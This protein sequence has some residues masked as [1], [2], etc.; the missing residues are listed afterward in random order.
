[1]ATAPQPWDRRPDEP[2]KAWYAFTIYRDLGIDKRSLRVVADRISR[3]QELEDSG[4]QMELPPVLTTVDLDNPDASSK[5]VARERQKKVHGRLF[6]WSSKYHW[7]DRCKGW[8]A[9]CQQHIE[10]RSLDRAEETFRRQQ[11]YN[12]SLAVSCSVIPAV[13]L[14]KLNTP[15]G[16]AW[17]DSIPMDD[18]LGLVIELTSRAKRM[19]D[20][21]RIALGVKVTPNEDAVRHFF[22]G[23]ETVQP[24]AKPTE[25]LEDVGSTGE[26]PY[27]VPPPHDPV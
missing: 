19:Q 3:E 15:E 5:R 2:P 1:M 22:W 14:R 20:A 8:D 12:K 24:P 25:L 18:L 4:S 21:E 10:K 17:L 11:D 13:F 6:S 16:R 27:D 26:D 7:V 23:L 9:F